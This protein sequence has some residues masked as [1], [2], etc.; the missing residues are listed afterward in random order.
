MNTLF[1]NNK[2]MNLFWLGTPVDINVDITKYF[3]RIR[4]FRFNLYYLAKKYVSTIF[5]KPYLMTYRF[6]DNPL[7]HAD[8]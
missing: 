3:H 5:G 2:K 7:R 8:R 4:I 6:L 1:S